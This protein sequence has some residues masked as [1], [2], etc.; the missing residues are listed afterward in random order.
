[1]AVEWAMKSLIGAKFI[2][3]MAL[4][5]L[6]YTVVNV[7]NKLAAHDQMNLRILVA[8]RM[9]FAAAATVPPSLVFESRKSGPE[10]T[11]R[12]ILLASV[13][14]LLGGTLNLN[15]YVA[16]LAMTSAT[17][18][19][20]M[21]NLVPAIT[22]LLAAIFRLEK[23]GTAKLVGTLIEICGAAVLTFYK[24]VEI[25]ILP[26]IIDFMHHDHGKTSSLHH[27]NILGVV[28]V[29]CYCFSAALSLIIHDKLTKIYPY[30]WTSTALISF[31]AL[32]QSVVFALCTERDMSHWRLGWDVRL[33]AVAFSGIFASGLATVVVAWCVQLKGPLF[34]SVFSPLTFV[35]VAISGSLVLD[36]KLHLGS[37][38]GFVLI[39]GGL[40]VMLWGKSKETTEMLTT[41]ETPLDHSANIEEAIEMANP[42]ETDTDFFPT[43]IS[44]C[45]DSPTFIPATYN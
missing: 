8:Y 33:L 11:W 13:I 25:N 1:M 44:C 3:L 38:I 12:V 20:A 42:V 14:A 22:F 17:F 37:I 24:G 41:I 36:E 40:L 18:A 6:V 23:W 29:V 10:I 32:V 4:V 15:M 45:D 43:V 30:P 16:S 34:V 27:N 21:T 5:Q 35:F 7:L 31:M 39:V 19:S 9:T 2:I 28:L 26:V